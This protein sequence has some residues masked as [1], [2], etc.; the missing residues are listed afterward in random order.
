MSVG[1]AS[2][3][4]GP[5]RGGNWKSVQTCVVSTYFYAGMPIIAGEPKSTSASATHDPPVTQRMPHP[6]E[7]ADTRPTTR[8]EA[9]EASPSAVRGSL[10]VGCCSRSGPNSPGAGV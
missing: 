4:V 1:S 10:S 8:A 6:P 5:T 7:R 2:A 9:Y 3:A